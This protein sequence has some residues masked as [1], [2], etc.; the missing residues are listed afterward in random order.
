MIPLYASARAWACAS[1]AATRRSTGRYARSGPARDRRHAPEQRCQT[2]AHA[3][4]NRGRSTA[5]PLRGRRS[6]RAG[7]TTTICPRFGGFVL[8]KNLAAHQRGN[9]CRERRHSRPDRWSLPGAAGRPK[10]GVI[11]ILKPV[12]ACF[13]KRVTLAVWCT[14]SRAGRHQEREFSGGQWNF[15]PPKQKGDAH[16]RDGHGHSNQSHLAR[17]FR[18]DVERDFG[19]LLQIQCIV[20]TEHFAAQDRRLS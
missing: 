17:D 12:N 6:T 1:S 10:P 4:A 19:R 5:S 13:L 20:G 18:R 9:P 11:S 2:P 3:R 7:C 15:S 14:P 16:G 8:I